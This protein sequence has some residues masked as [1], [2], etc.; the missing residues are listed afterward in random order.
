MEDTGED[1]VFHSITNAFFKN[2]QYGDFPGDPVAK[3]LCAQCRRSGVRSLV[4]KLFHV[5]QVKVL[6]AT[7]KTW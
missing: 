7:T 4:R 3:T 6:C 5:P 2:K 1:E